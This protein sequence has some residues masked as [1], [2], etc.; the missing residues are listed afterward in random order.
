MKHLIIGAGE[1]GQSLKHVFKNADIHDVKPLPKK[2]YDIL[3]ISFPYSKNFEAQVKNYQKRYDADYTVIH[4]TVPLGTSRKLN[5]CHSPVTGKHPDLTESLYTFKKPLAGHGSDVIRE[6]FIKH[7][8][9]P[10]MYNE[11]EECEASKL[12]ELN[13]YGINILLQKD[14]AKYCEKHNLDFDNVYTKMVEKYNMG[15][16]QM[17]LDH[18]KMFKLKNMKGKL[19]GHCVVQ[20]AKNLKHF[21]GW[22]LI[23]KNKLL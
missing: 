10:L 9:A 22:L 12:W 7:G 19:G 3:H 17:G 16:S 21:W 1:I 18:Y 8:V 11:P 14:I 5:A 13:I 6:E 23:L 20:N 4:S 2:N 15:Y